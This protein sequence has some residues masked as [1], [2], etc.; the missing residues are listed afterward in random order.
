MGRGGGGGG[1][2]SFGG[3]SFSSSRSS[4]S[5]S[6]SGGRG[7]SFSGG[8]RGSSGGY[9]GGMGYRPPPP[10]P[11]RYYGGGVSYH[12]HR[13][14]RAGPVASIISAIVVIIFIMAVLGFVMSAGSG[15]VTKST[16]NR[17]P[18]P[19]GNVQTTDFWYEYR[20]AGEDNW[21][22]NTTELESGMRKFYKE[23]GVQPF[24]YL[25]GTVNGDAYPS[26]SEVEA[27]ACDLYDQLF[28]DEGHFLLV[29]QNYDDSSE[30][31]MA[32]VTGTAAETV[33]DD[34]AANIIMDYVEYRY[35]TNDTEEELFS[36]AFSMSADRIMTVTKSPWIPI[37]GLG[38]VIILVVILFNIWKA[39][40]AQKNRED[41]ATERILNTP[42]EKIGHKDDLEDKYSD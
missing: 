35:T 1:G 28:N 27:F 16:R 21:I 12:Y 30:Y 15:S 14:Y 19:A 37:L 5:R 42:V 8:H 4:G 40:K 34:E 23:T 22:G 33:I 41:E 13:S 24:L 36:N 9:R 25:T 2:R 26:T 20:E 11:P 32:Y 10:P 38:G 29:F 39:V 3:S 17:T 6:S 7:S 31:Q 18:L